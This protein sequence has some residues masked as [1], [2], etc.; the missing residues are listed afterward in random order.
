MIQI[1]GSPVSPYVKKALA[2]LVMKGVE[3]AVDP[4]TPFYGD[5]TF[6]E[7][8]PL[9]RVPVFID[10]DLTLNDSS[11][12]AHYIEERWPAPSASSSPST[13]GCRSATGCRCSP[14]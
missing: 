7:L 4:I 14:T 5:E 11:V 2:L 10:G 3:F 12:I 1:I 13:T 8:S 6:S 9:R